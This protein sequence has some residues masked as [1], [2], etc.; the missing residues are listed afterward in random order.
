MDLQTY[1]PAATTLKKLFFYPASFLDQ[2]N[3]SIFPRILINAIPIPQ[4]DLNGS[5][6]KHKSSVKGIPMGQ[7]SVPW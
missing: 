3:F 2:Q 7:T 1:F 6:S 4:D 5:F